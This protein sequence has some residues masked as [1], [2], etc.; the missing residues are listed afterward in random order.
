[1]Y[2][3]KLKPFQHAQVISSQSQPS[4][5]DFQSQ[6]DLKKKRIFGSGFVRTSPGFAR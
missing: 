2:K 3:Y 1:M 5:E 4:K 6:R